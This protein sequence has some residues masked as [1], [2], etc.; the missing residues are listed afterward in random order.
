MSNDIKDFRE[1]MGLTQVAFRK[2]I[3]VSRSYVYYLERGERKPS[4]T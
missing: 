3:K 1:K 2:S 4:K